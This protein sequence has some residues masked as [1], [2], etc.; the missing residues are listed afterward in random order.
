[1][2]ELSEEQALLKAKFYRKNGNIAEAQK[3]YEAVLKA[4]PRNKKAQQSLSTIKKLYETRNIQNPPQE[5]INQ[6]TN[7][8]N[9]GQLS[10]VIEEAQTL[11]EHYP[12]DAFIWNIWGASAAQI[13]KLDQAVFAFQKVISL[14]PVYFE[15]YNNMGNALTNQGKLDAAI[16]AYKAALLLNPDYADA[17]NNMGIAL[18]N[19]GK[20]DEAIEA[21][22]AALS[23][24]SLIHISEPTRPY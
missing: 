21:Y 22:K 7:L 9:Q 3:M 5:A 1:M 2:A 23:L 19:Q 12:C 20:L 24:L 11:A 10:A 17:Y 8:Y 13:A 15:A 4:F 16:E 14:K 6:L 18:T